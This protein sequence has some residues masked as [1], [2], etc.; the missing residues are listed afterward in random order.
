L[1]ARQTS[2]LRDKRQRP[3]RERERFGPCFSHDQEVIGVAHEGQAHRLDFLIE[4]VEHD[5]GQ[6]RRQGA[7]L[8]HA[9]GLR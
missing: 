6:Q 1:S 5:I 9:L 4:R 3:L 7:A 2:A 8:R